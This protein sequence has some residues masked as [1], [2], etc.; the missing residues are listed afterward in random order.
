MSN[1]NEVVMSRDI[2]I[3][4]WFDKSARIWGGSLK[5]RTTGIQLGDAW[6]GISRDEVLVNGGLFFYAEVRHRDGEKVA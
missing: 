4:V 6:W 3:E 5:D 1:R 2:S